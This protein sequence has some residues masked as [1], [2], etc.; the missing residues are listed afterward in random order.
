MSDTIIKDE[1]GNLQSTVPDELLEDKLGIK[2][3]REKQYK[4]SIISKDVKGYNAMWKCKVSSE[5]AIKAGSVITY[6]Y[7]GELDKDK[8]E[9]FEIEG[10]GSRKNDGYGNKV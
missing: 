2:I 10:I 5:T 3:I 1:F 8:I 4:A 6:G 9:Q 7:E